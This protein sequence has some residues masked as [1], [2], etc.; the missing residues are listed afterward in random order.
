M[1]CAPSDRPTMSGQVLTNS[2]TSSRVVVRGRAKCAPMPAPPTRTIPSPSARA[3]ARMPAAE[4][5]APAD[6]QKPARSSRSSTS[7]ASR[8]PNRKLLV[9]DT[10]AAPAP[11]T[12]ANGTRASTPASSR[13]RKACSRSDSVGQLLAHQRAGDAE[14]D[15][16]QPRSRCRRAGRAPDGRTATAAIARP[17]GRTARRCRRAHAACGPTPTARSTGTALQ[18]YRQLCRPP[19]RHRYATECPARA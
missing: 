14:R 17:C 8:S 18:V 13:S 7:S 10:R 15:D 12:R 1:R 4:H 9:F 11:L 6:A 3:R 5:A 16:A 19:A 2:S